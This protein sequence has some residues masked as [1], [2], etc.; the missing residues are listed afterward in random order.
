MSTIVVFLQQEKGK[1]NSAA[2][3]AIRAAQEFAKLNSSPSIQGLCLGEQSDQAAQS[4]LKFGLSKV[5]FSAQPEFSSYVGLVYA[6]A[7]A[8]LAR[9]VSATTVIAASTSTGKDFLPAVAAHLGAGMASEVLSFQ[10]NGIFLRPMY[11][12]NV[13][14]EVKIDSPVKVVSIRSSAFSAAEPVAEGGEKEEFSF[15]V[16]ADKYGEVLEFASSASGRPELADA[17]IV[18]SGGRGVQSKEG[19][20]KYVTPLAD[21]LNAAVG[22]SRAAV[23]AGF[24]PNDWQVGQTGK[25]VAPQLYVA[26]GVSGAIQ[27]LA[28]MKDS[29]VVVAINKDPEA[30]IFEIADYGLVADLEKAVPEL[31]ELISKSK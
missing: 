28:G 31:L 5:Y 7:V 18:V 3:S 30:P 24:A 13:L 17:K 22:A 4:A 1:L 19:F 23:D 14:A 21:A 15:S 11:A 6:K 25:T 9:K 8:E 12:G 27:H 29:K 2:L 20:E 26:I 16:S 10:T